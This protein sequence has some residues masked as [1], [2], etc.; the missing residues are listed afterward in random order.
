MLK[1]LLISTRP[2]TNITLDFITG[3]P[4]NNGYNTVLM[5]IDQLTKKRHYILYTTVENSTTAEA[6]TYLLL[7]NV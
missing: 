3:L 1:P 6:T 7:N 2:W 4:L 5:V